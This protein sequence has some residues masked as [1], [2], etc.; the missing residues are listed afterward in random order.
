MTTNLTGLELRRK[1]CEALG[2]WWEG[3][4]TVGYWH[5][6]KCPNPINPGHQG[7]DF[8]GHPS[9]MMVNETRTPEHLLPAIE[10]DPAVALTM[11]VEFCEKN[12]GWDWR[13][14]SARYRL[15]ATCTIWSADCVIMG[16][17][18]GSTPCEA[19]A[20]AI[21]EAHGQGV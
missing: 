15:G 9:R 1:A 6:P 11:L 4:R 12:D 13:L 8:E 16:H 7:C 10:S 17:A 14:Q 19:I 20:R 21:V 2:Y 5:T 3:G 18:D